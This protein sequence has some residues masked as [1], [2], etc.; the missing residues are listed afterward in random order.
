MKLK[1]KYIF[2]I[3][4][5]MIAF[6]NQSTVYAS[7][8]A[9]HVED[10]DLKHIESTF[11]EPAEKDEISTSEEIS[12][13][14]EKNIS[15]EISTSGEKNISEEISTSKEI[16]TFEEISISEE[17]GAFEEISAF[18]ETSPFETYFEDDVVA[19]GESKKISETEQTSFSEAEGENMSGIYDEELYEVDDTEEQSADNDENERP[20]QQEKSDLTITHADIESVYKK[21]IE[22]GSEKWIGDDEMVT[23]SAAWFSDDADKKWGGDL[24]ELSAELKPEIKSVLA[25]KEGEAAVITHF[26]LMQKEATDFLEKNGISYA[27]PADD[28]YG[29]DLIVC[30]KDGIRYTRV[31]PKGSADLA[32]ETQDFLKSVEQSAEHIRSRDAHQPFRSGEINGYVEVTNT[33]T[34]TYILNE[35]YSENISCSFHTWFYLSKIVYSD[36][37]SSVDV[38]AYSYIQPHVGA[39]F[40]TNWYRFGMYRTSIAQ[41]VY[42]TPMTDGVITLGDSTS[43]DFSLGFPPSIGA[44]LSIRLNEGTTL[45]A[46]IKDQG[47]NYG[48][49][50]KNDEGVYGR[51]TGYFYH[52][53]NVKFHA[54]A[55]AQPFRFF[56]AH[57]F[58]NAVYLY[59]ANS[60]MMGNE[61]VLVPASS[62]SWENQG[63]SSGGNSY[64]IGG[65]DYGLVFDPSY[66]LLNNPDVYAAYGNDT[67]AAFFHFLNNGMSEARQAKDSFHPVHYR[68][69]Y[70]DLNAA[71]GDDW[72]QYYIHYIQYGYA[73]NRDGS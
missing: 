6:P 44:D 33:F 71:F 1:Y 29:V 12:T 20:D 46:W 67:Q 17:I 16:S 69:R 60:H 28:P 61:W 25:L 72:E 73:E 13:S 24:N 36:N 52:A 45:Q 51:N 58:R 47:T 64:I 38:T 35:Q 34:D 3:W 21:E 18:E 37:S 62:I 7:S 54:P 2:F 5:A 59:G 4:L 22:A 53:A 41:I 57:L 50:Y 32:K 23:D 49:N 10:I 19:Y 48:A 56:Y 30:Q 39:R 65:L 8:F 55:Q 15:E 27:F 43:L 63:G 9:S 26:D 40:C 70:P 31:Y 14:G 66:Y 11:E 68:N 42:A